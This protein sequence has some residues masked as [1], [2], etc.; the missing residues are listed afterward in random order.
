MDAVPNVGIPTVKQTL[1]YLKKQGYGRGG[2]NAI[3]AARATARASNVANRRATSTKAKAVKVQSKSGSSGPG[4][5]AGFLT[6]RKVK[7]TKKSLMNRRGVDLTMETGGSTTSKACTYI[8]HATAPI[9]QLRNTAVTALMKEL[10]LRA[11]ADV[12]SLT[13]PLEVQNT[14]KVIVR[15]GF[16]TGSGLNS[17]TYSMSAGDSIISVVAWFTS[18][19]R[20]WNLDNSDADQREF[21]SVQFLPSDNLDYKLRPT[22]MMM[23]Q[24]KVHFIARSALKMQNRTVQTEGDNEFTNVDNVPL[25]GKTYEGNGT[26]TIYL[27]TPPTGG[28]RPVFYANKENSVI[29]SDNGDGC[30][31]EPPETSQFDVVRREGKIK[32]DPGEIKTSILSWKKSMKFND[33]WNMVYPLS[34]QNTA[35]K[36]IGT[37]R[38]FAIEKMIH[39]TADVNDTAIKTVY[40]INYDLS[41]KFTFTTSVQS[42][43]LLVEFR[44][45][46]EQV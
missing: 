30:P 17:D 10:F 27:K 38:L 2:K 9:I 5:S 22:L 35:V 14:D 43:K 3:A 6:T 37:Y 31:L 32:L 25:Y 18:P 19:L 46:N 4:R 24:C 11:G 7:K 28:P 45:V 15:F 40:E 29:L 39:F 42:R 33:F 16:H 13:D 36:P 1:A 21:Y 12:T 20:G 44:D 8:G 26:G 41:C 34:G 23:K